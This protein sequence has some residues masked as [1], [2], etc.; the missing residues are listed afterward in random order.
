MASEKRKGKWKLV[1]GIV[2]AII[3]VG[4]AGWYFLGSKGAVQAQAV[5]AS[6]SKGTIDVKV[7]GTGNV[8]PADT[9]NVIAKGS[10]S[11]AG[12][13]VANGQH[14]TKGQ[15]LF[16]LDASNV[17]SQIN[18]ARLDQKLTQLDIGNTGQQLKQQQIYAPMSGRITSIQVSK[19]QDVQKGAALMTIQ[20]ISN[21]SFE[22]LFNDVSDIQA[23]QKADVTIT[24]LGAS[25]F[26]GKVTKVNRSAVA[27]NN[28][29]LGYYVTIAISN[30]GA[31]V[32]GMQAQAVVHTAR[33]VVPGYNTG[34]LEWATTTILRA[35]VAGNLTGLNVDENTVVKKGQLIASLNSDTLKSQVD[36]Q[37]LKLQQSQ[38]SIS[39]LQKQLADYMIY[40][41]AD[42]IFTMNASADTSSSK[43]SSSSSTSTNV[44]DKWQVG[45]EVK[46]GQIVGIID[47]SAGMVV[48]VPVDEVDIA[49]IKLGQKADITFD[50]LPDQIYTGS[51][52][53]I[54]DQGVVAN[55]AATFDVKVALDKTNGVKTGMTANVEILVNH[56]NGALLV[57][58]EAVQDRNGRKFVILDTGGAVGGVAGGTR[59]SGSGSGFGGNSRAN[60][61]T[62]SGAQ[63]GN[64]TG[65][66]MT[67]VE[68]GLYNETSI[69]IISG[70][71]E[72]DKVVLPTVARSSGNNNRSPFG[73]GMGGGRPEGAVVRTQG[74][75]G[76]NGQ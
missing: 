26:T 2:A 13:N 7:S 38:L 16:Q 71:K 34:L 42:G 19:G 48:T 45:D 58:I 49:K 56:K 70:V 30:P 25:G 3:V 35:G 33:G 11:I 20:D 66:R 37:S 53:D 22:L 32:P 62:E 67:R 10:G 1:T 4:L 36:S 12:V 28:G 60:S 54:S 75:G 69:E 47:D 14:V 74:G 50:A 51:V 57:P 46:A 72:G 43:N 63:S 8:E 27:D 17:Q 44:A 55:S 65:G 18:K 61:G 9:S 41:P 73:G 29:T 68:T 21:L 76:N 24:D 31:V 59:R 6:V 52:S 64:A 5:T 15:L 39:D 40:A 23:G